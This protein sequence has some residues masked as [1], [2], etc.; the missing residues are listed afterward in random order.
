[1]LPPSP[2]LALPFL[3]CCSAVLRPW[4]LNGSIN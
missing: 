2:P 1:L 4:K 3:L